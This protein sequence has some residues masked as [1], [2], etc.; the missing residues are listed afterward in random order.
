MEE[1][2]GVKQPLLG[3]LG[4]IVCVLLTMAII[5]WFKTP[6]FMSWVTFIMICAIP[7]MVVLALVWQG[8]YP[9][10][11]ATLAQPLKGVYLLLLSILAGAAI[12]GVMLKILP[13]F[14]LPGPGPAQSHYIILT[15]VV[16]LWLVI[17]WQCW[18]TAAIKGHPAFVGIG[19]VILTYIVTWI[20]FKIF[21]NFGVMAKAPFYVASADPGGLFVFADSMAFAVT[22]VVVLL[23]FVLLDM[24]PLST[25]PPKIP[26]MAKPPV[27]GIVMSILVLIITYIIFKVGVTVMK[28]PTVFLVKITI[29]WIFGE[30]IMLNCLQT[31][32]F[33]TVAQPLKG[34]LLIIC[35]FILALIM[36]PIYGAMA[37]WIAGSPLPAGAKG[38]YV[39]ELWIG[40]AML[41]VTFP[42]F[43]AFTGFFNFWPF[44]EGAPPPPPEAAAPNGPPPS[45]LE[46]SVSQHL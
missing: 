43:T 42:L 45:S 34:I 38:G 37:T 11:A 15:V 12:A 29:S 32:P 14:N 9:A 17:A 1:Q 4:L 3:I 28:D 20:V 21:W 41:G 31:A 30:F 40:S 18:P 46:E 27:W 8:N 36:Y 13:G 6:T 44:T 22:T 35:S 39:H 2:S 7:T 19:T 23:G 16:T 5:V 33:Q 26:A 24:W 10:P 25:L